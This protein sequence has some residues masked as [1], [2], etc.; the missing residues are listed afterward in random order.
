MTIAIVTD[1]TS[2]L[3]APLR[4]MH[5]IHQIPAALIIK[6]QSYRDGVD[7][8]RREYYRMLPDLKDLPTTASPSAGDFSALYDKLLSSGFEKII[9]IHLSRKLSGMYNTA[10]VAAGEFKDRVAAVDSG[11]VS[12]GL[13]FQAL[14]AAKAAAAGQ[15]VKGVI[16]RIRAAQG[17]IHLFAL[18]DTL[19]YILKSGRI[20]WIKA[21]LGKFLNLKPLLQLQDGV[22]LNAG[23]TRLRG[24]AISRLHEKVRELGPLR[25]LAVLHTNAEGDGKQFLSRYQD[26]LPG[27]ALLVNVTTSIGTHVGPN[28]LGFVAMVK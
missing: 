28:G 13:G 19:D 7:I 24:Q 2:D 23:F 3:P 12:L 10:K 17:K 8:S 6:G 25:S 18:L 11:Q 14:E 16:A 9:S 15:P 1:S 5:N 20:P 26:S 4:E 27:R 21:S 22:V